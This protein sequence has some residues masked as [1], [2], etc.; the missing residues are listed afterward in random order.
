M[1]LDNAKI[2][3]IGKNGQ[4][5]EMTPEAY[6]RFLET[7][8]LLDTAGKK[9]TVRVRTVNYYDPKEHGNAATDDGG[10]RY[11]VNLDAM[12]PYFLNE[13]LEALKDKDYAKAANSNLTRSVYLR[14]DGTTRKYVPKVDE[15][16]NIFMDEVERPVLDED[17][18]EQ[19]DDEGNQIT[20][21]RLSIVSMTEMQTS[22]A[23]ST[24]GL[25]SG[26]I[27]A[28]EN[29]SSGKEKKKE[30]KEVLSNEPPV[31]S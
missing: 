13:A 24:K 12:T 14:P 3:L 16:V 11:I 30:V 23:R 10:P 21:I 25:F 29:E 15:L 7:R 18:N 27:S 2:S 17:G 4:V 1:N 20:E 6:E 28:S 26:L 31:I 8:K 5:T 19:F 22:K 9:Y